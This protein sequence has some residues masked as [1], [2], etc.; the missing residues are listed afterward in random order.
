MKILLCHERFL[1]RFG[2]D[3][4]MLLIARSLREQGHAIVTLAN[5]FDRDI[6]E[7]FAEQILEVDSFQGDY[8]GL[9]EFSSTWIR[10][11]WDSFFPPG[12][13]PDLV[14]HGGWPFFSAIPFFRSRSIPVVFMDHGVVPTD[15]FPEGH[16]AVLDRLKQLRRQHLRQC[17]MITGVSDFI[18]QS[19]S[20]PD[21]LKRVPVRR[22]WNGA[23]HMD[24]GLW[25]F[26][27]S[28][29][30]AVD[31]RS[32]QNGS[33][34][35]PRVLCL[36]RWETTGYKNCG[37]VFDL[38]RQLKQSGSDPLFLVLAENAGQIGAPPDLASSFRP[39]GLPS[40]AELSRL[41]AGVDLGVC[42][43][44]W[45]GFNLPLAE[46][47]WL[48]KPAF[49]LDAGAHREVA[50]HPHFVCRD[51]PDMG[52]RVSAWLHGKG[53]ARQEHEAAL[54]A[55][56]LQFTWKRVFRAYAEIVEL[57]GTKQA[58]VPA[59]VEDG[60]IHLIV[61]VTNATRDPANSGV[62]RITRRLSQE[63]QAYE[64]P[65]FVVWDTTAG[66]Y[67]LPTVS[68]FAQLGQFN[69]PVPTSPER[70]S[71]AERR[72]TLD[73]ALARFGSRDPWLL[74]TETMIETRFRHIRPYARQRN[75]KL[76]AIFYDAIPVLRPELCN[77]EMKT[78]HA[79]YM[80]GLAQCD[81]VIP[82]SEYSASTL[83]A[84][85]SE[86][87]LGGTE[88]RTHLLPG[89][90]GGITRNVELD[91]RQPEP[92]TI[93]CVSTLEPR[94]NHRRLLA[95]CQKMEAAHPELDWKLILVGN[96]YAGAMD[97]AEYVERVCAGNRR[98]EWRGIVDDD[99]LRRLY[100]ECH[101][102]VYASEIEGFGLPVVESLW[103]GRPC[104]CH[105]E[106]VMSELAAGGGCMTTD[107]RNEDRL[108]GDIYRLASDVDLRRKLAA[109]AVSRALKSWPDY[110]NGV[111]SSIASMDAGV[112]RAATP[113]LP[114]DT[115]GSAVQPGWQ[116]RLYSDC[117]LQN[118]QMNESERLALAGL[119]AR[120][121]PKCSVEVGT[122]KGGSLSLISQ[123]SQ[124]VFSIDVDPEIPQ[125][126][127]PALP[128]VQFLTGNSGTMLPVLL[129][130][131]TIAGIPVDFIL[132]D[133]DHSEAGIKRD[134]DIVLGYVP[135]RPMFVMLH[136]SMNPQCRQGMLNA[137]WANSVYCHW[138][139]L[140][141]IPGRII[142]HGGGGHGELWGG[143]ALAY[144]LPTPRR[145]ELHVGQS[146]VMMGSILREASAEMA[147]R[148]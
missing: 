122:F 36:G 97:L 7:T 15:G 11:R 75:V 105:E 18:L 6:V 92:F 101:I 84:L 33:G 95:A 130:E 94:K 109:E 103:H 126:L 32:A 64:D 56:R 14:L 143:L 60:R 114:D 23:D 19:Q 31:D 26:V 16:R 113:L 43:S 42:L 1:F 79:A 9:D 100:R 80:R 30:A 96:R 41:M 144:F 89:E 13:E 128:N 78:N 121:Q 107:V 86:W 104:L 54:Q 146:A 129:E 5:R 99:T 82:I 148:G 142:E 137:A 102:T 133:G 140:D 125:L 25:D 83:H 37:A 147:G 118:W 46:M 62:I 29:A 111:L 68:E 112:A 27:P 59:A 35:R 117:R 91:T 38:A 8:R 88:V 115:P 4:V 58:H 136:D 49:V 24:S 74:M 72:I 17:S 141:F 39:V 98:M 138:V 44:L 63:V 93:L 45:E 90:F 66:E 71:D 48:G 120:H 3:R 131:L 57:L 127:S 124:L 85:W 21:S 77:E 47:Q 34:A 12:S 70:I 123:Y 40:D 10:D 52:I 134:L 22:V 132:I 73:E 145:G 106:G 135:V 55:F 76:A 28:S 53:L 139:D 110:A 108:A 61:D 69:G 67:V 119:L 50:A 65:L 81:L 87:G 116:D 2:A 51:L 20:I